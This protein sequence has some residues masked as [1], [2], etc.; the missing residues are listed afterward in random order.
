VSEDSAA[1]GG[2][3]T[4]TPAP[5]YAGKMDSYQPKLRRAPPCQ[6]PLTLSAGRLMNPFPKGTHFEVRLN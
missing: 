6:K 2:V 3:F 1:Q 4:Q 5:L